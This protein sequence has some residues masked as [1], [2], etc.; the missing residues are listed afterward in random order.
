V[1]VCRDCLTLRRL[2]VGRTRKVQTLFGT[3][4]VDAPRIRACACRN[5]WGF[6]DVSQ[7]PLAELLPD[8]C[9]PEL[10]RLQA[11]LSARHSYREA[12]ARPLAALLPCAK[13]LGMRAGEQTFRG[14]ARR[15]ACGCRGID[16]HVPPT[17]G[18]VCIARYSGR[19]RCVRAI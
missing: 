17:K 8:R 12:A 15:I 4:I 9:T 16:L 6:V 2:R 14:G 10:R 3:I 19:G 13:M 11:E 1:C 7:S 18:K 5:H